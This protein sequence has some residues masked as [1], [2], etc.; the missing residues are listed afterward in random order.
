[1]LCGDFKL[2]KIVINQHERFAECLNWGKILVTI[3]QNFAIEYFLR[4]VHAFERKT[5]LIGYA[6]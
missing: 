5:L 6:W 2:I 1:M 3:S 4:D